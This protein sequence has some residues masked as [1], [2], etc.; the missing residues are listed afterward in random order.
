MVVVAGARAAVAVGGGTVSWVPERVEECP[1][2]TCG[3]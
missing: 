3:L 1:V 2:R